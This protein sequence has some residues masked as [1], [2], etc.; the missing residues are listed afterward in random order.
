MMTKTQVRLLL[1]LASGF[2]R[3]EVD[4][5]T[6]LAWHKLLADADYDECVD[7]IL[8]HQVGPLRG[9]Y[10]TVGHVTDAIRARHRA[11]GYAVQ[12]DIRSAKAR[13][14]IPRDWPE[15]QPLD[16]GT[17][18]RLAQMRADEA[19]VRQQIDESTARHAISSAFTSGLVLKQV[20]R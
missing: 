16:A 19:G 17:A 3:R 8:E 2:D 6:S 1:S 14:M 15:N 13:R 12:A 20:P 10:L 7:I 11:G 4:D 9:E 18:A 5:L